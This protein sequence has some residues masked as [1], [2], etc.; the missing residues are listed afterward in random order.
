MKNVTIENSVDEECNYR[1]RS[2]AKASF[3]KK[4]ARPGP[5][6]PVEKKVLK[7]NKIKKVEEK[8]FEFF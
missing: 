7:I 8:N 1:L 4:L 5:A 6:L 2:K 3:Y